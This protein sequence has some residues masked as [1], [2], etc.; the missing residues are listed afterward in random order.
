M[1]PLREEKQWPFTKKRTYQK[2][3]VFSSSETQALSMGEVIT[4]S[5]IRIVTS[6]HMHRTCARSHQFGMMCVGH[7]LYP[8]SPKAF[9]PATN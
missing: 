1:W 4:Y 6:V 7:E 5:C 8:P 2:A 9:A 3:H